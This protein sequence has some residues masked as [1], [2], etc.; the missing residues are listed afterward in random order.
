MGVAQCMRAHTFFFHM[1]GEVIFVY[2]NG[3]M[4]FPILLLLLH[5]YM[6]NDTFMIAIFISDRAS[7]KRAF[8]CFIRLGMVSVITSLSD[9]LDMYDMI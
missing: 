3:L 7:D 1:E 9:A 5:L 2:G 4:D 6:Y 8:I